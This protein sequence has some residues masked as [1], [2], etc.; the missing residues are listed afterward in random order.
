MT[1][2]LSQTQMGIYVTCMNCKEG[3]YNIDLLYTLDQDIDLQRLAVALDKVIEAH[4]Y[5]KSRLVIDDNGNVGFEDHSSEPF[6]TKIIDAV[7]IDDYNDHIGSDYDL[8]HDSLFRLEIY[9]TGGGCP[10]TSK[11]A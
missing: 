1:Y 9:R 5:V 2:P 10:K 11:R 4:P 7:N 3:R 6:H 8:L